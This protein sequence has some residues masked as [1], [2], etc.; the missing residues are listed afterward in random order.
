MVMA[1]APPPAM[2]MGQ[3][4]LPT[5]DYKH[6][7]DKSRLLYIHIIA[8]IEMNQPVWGLSAFQHP[9]TSSEKKKEWASG[10]LALKMWFVHLGLSV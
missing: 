10:V 9:G 6:F 8:A 5:A 1:G 2:K 4:S 7:H 3:I